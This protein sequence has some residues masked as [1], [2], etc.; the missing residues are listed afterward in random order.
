MC[1]RRHA[2]ERVR[3]LSPPD[4]HAGG[5]RRR[6]YGHRAPTGPAALCAVS[7]SARSQNQGAWDPW[8]RHQ[9]TA[10]PSPERL[11]TGA[12]KSRAA[13]VPLLSAGWVAEAHAGSAGP[14]PC[15]PAHLCP[16]PAQAWDQ[17]PESP[18]HRPW[19]LRLRRC[20]AFGEDQQPGLADLYPGVSGPIGSASSACRRS[21]FLTLCRRRVAPPGS[22]L[23]EGI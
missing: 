14:D 10:H 2:A 20:P 23:G 18:S 3:E 22:T 21:A 7:G 8:G 5:E 1:A 4:T 13:R 12:P 9:P 17:R 19:R 11:L 6:S 15:S 16:V